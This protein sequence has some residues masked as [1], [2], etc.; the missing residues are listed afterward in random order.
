MVLKFA[1]ILEG[2]II[3]QMACQGLN[4]YHI[5]FNVSLELSS[6]HTNILI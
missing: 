1:E 4:H 6:F 2:I 5:L 3:T